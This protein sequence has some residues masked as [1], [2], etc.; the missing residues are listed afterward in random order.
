M[1]PKRVVVVLAPSIDPPKRLS[2]GADVVAAGV[3]PNIPPPVAA[4]EGADPKMSPV[5]EAVVLVVLVK[6]EGPD[7]AAVAAVGLTKLKGVEAW[8]A[9]EV[10]ALK[11]DGPDDVVAVGLVP[12]NRLDWEAAGVDLEVEAS[13]MDLRFSV[14]AA[15]A[16]P[17]LMLRPGNDP[18]PPP[19]L[20]PPLPPPKDEAPPEAGW[21]KNDISADCVGCAER[22]KGERGRG[23]GGE[24]QRAGYSAVDCPPIRI[25]S[26]TRK[27]RVS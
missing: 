9:A 10:V 27:K 6:R 13:K 22:R 5:L 25:A 12:P 11:G 15:W 23:K 18:P 1:L 4:V 2:E 24:E 19:P 3:D 21:P 7:E 17:V 8:G 14:D 26:S 16:A 20:P